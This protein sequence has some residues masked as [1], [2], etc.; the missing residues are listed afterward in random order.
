LV[1]PIPTA[2]VAGLPSD[3]DRR[4]Q[5]A[6]KKS[7][8]LSPKWTVTWI[9]S[10]SRLQGL[11]PSQIEMV[12]S[13][14]ADVGG[15]HLLVFRG[16]DRS[17][18]DLIATEVGPYFRVRWL[19]HTWPKLIPH[20]LPRFFANIN[21]VLA[22]ELTW[23]E[24]VKPQDESCCLLLPQRAFVAAA[25]VQHVWH[26][27]TEPGT[28]RIKLAAKAAEK[29]GLRHWMA[30]HN[31]RHASRNWIDN[32]DRVFDH[33]GPRH[34]AAPFPRSWKYSFEI[35]SGF[36]FDVTSR[37][38]R[39]FHVYAHDGTRHGAAGTDHVNIDPHGVV[40]S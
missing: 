15:A 34:G 19:D 1:E 39:A 37:T 27:A 32:Y 9:R 35:A 3:I 36:H 16:R 20:D 30:H 6:L 2:I 33:R 12:R 21:D 29:F 10:H 18:E 23:R 25:E 26:A 5:A 28:E 11:V 22:E 13:K 7:S 24:L 17:E 31:Q 8:A 38:S 40:R 14:A 4:V